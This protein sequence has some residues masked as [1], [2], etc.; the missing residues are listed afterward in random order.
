MTKQEAIDH[1]GGI[2]ELADKLKISYH[3]VYQWKEIPLLR[4]CQLE[5]MTKRKLKADKL[6]A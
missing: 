6:A 1:F 3:A 2:K 4:Q 5:L